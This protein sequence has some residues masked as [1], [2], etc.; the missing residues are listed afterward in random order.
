MNFLII[1]DTVPFPPLNGK[2]LPAAKLFGELCKRYKV[3][4]LVLSFNKTADEKRVPE[5]PENITLLD[6]IPVKRKNRK[7][8][9][10]QSLKPAAGSFNWPD[11]IIK[12]T[13]AGKYYHWVWIYPVTFIEFVEHAKKL[14]LDFYSKIAVGL[15]DSLTYLYRD[16]M[17]ELIQSRQIKKRYI[18]DWVKSFSIASLEKRLLKNVDL[19]HV[20]TEVEKKKLQKLLGQSTKALIV[21]AP[22]GTKE[23]LFGCSYKGSRSNLILFMTHL[24]GGRVDESEWFCKKVWPLVAQKIPV[25]KLLIVGKPPVKQLDYIEKYQSI[26]INGYAENLEAIF[27]SVRIA[28]VPTFHG[29]GLINRILDSLTAGVPA[30]STPQAVATFPGLIDG[31]H[32]LSAKDPE[33]FAAHVIALYN[34]ENYAAQIATNGRSYAAAFPNWSQF[35]ETFEHVFRSC[36]H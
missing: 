5:I 7:T 10:M 15:N 23:E 18:T 36:L 30:V 8:R 13:L 2:E 3:D 21:V 25:A 33:L 26:I 22:N 9:L 11:A 35:V 14:K 16:S 27:N 28:V 1:A 29:T 19:I 32:I 20:Q 34:N 24:D 12:Q 31:T 17:N 4:L 6:I